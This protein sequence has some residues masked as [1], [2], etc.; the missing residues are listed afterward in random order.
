MDRRPSNQ[1]D[2]NTQP[3]PL[4]STDCETIEWYYP[5]QTR[6]VEVDGIQVTIRFVGRKGRR[7][8]ISIEA[9]AG[10]VFR[11]ELHECGERES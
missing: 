1:R 11:S 2:Q 7:A 9:P 5:G 10:A 4:D 8:R 6:T 3:R